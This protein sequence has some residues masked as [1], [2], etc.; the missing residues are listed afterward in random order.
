[1]VERDDGG[2]RVV[3]TVDNVHDE[4]AIGLNE[5]ADTIAG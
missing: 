4:L 1:L 5:R 2:S 3:E